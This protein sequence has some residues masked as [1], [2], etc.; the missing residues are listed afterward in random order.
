MLVE[1]PVKTVTAPCCEVNNAY[2]L[3]DTI[4]KD[5]ELLVVG[6]N[7]LSPALLTNLIAR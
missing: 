4:L 3:V 5:P 6:I 2:K 1:F 7:S